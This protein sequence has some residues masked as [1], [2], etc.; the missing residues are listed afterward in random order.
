MKKAPFN[1]QEYKDE[2]GVKEL[3]GRKVLHHQ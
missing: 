3:W 1:E 2:L